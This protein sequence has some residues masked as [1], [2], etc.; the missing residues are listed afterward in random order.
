MD[1]SL[2]PADPETMAAERRKAKALKR[3]AWWKNRIGQGRCHYCG[4]QVP[5]RELTMDHK[6]PLVRGGRT[7]RGN[8]VPCCPRCNAAKQNLPPGA[9][10]AMVEEE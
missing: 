9:W 10:R 1:D 7:S 6:V 8:C 4:Q 5:P 2:I 3:S